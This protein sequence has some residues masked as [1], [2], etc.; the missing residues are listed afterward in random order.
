MRDQALAFGDIAVGLDDV[1]RD[2]IA[3]GYLAAREQRAQGA[4]TCDLTPP[5]AVAPTE[6][7]LSRG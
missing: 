3:G 2:E 1:G 6:E 5:P 4:A 7:S